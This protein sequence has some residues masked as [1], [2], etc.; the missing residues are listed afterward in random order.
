MRLNDF[1][2]CQSKFKVL[3]LASLGGCPT[4]CKSQHISVKKN[5]E[6]KKLIHALYYSSGVNFFEVWNTRI[7]KRN[8]LP[9]KFNFFLANNTESNL[10]QV[11]PNMHYLTHFMFLVSLYTP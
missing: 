6:G 7:K 11:L 10:L 8:G 4:D 3:E 5:F 2:E 1:A 9:F